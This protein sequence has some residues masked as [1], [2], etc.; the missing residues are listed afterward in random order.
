[1]PNKKLLELMYKYDYGEMCTIVCN[2]PSLLDTPI[3]VDI[4]SF[5][6]NRIYLLNENVVVTYY[7]C[8]NPLVLNQFKEEIKFFIQ[9]G[10][11]K[12]FAFLP[13]WFIKENG[14]GEIDKIV[15]IQ[16]GGVLPRFSTDIAVE[17]MW[18]GYTVT[19]V[20]MQIA[21]HMGFRKLRLI[22][23]DHDY[24]EVKKPNL[25]TTMTTVDEHHFSPDYFKGYRWN[26]PD[27]KRSEL[28]YSLAK[29][30]FAEIT[31]MSGR[32]KLDVFDVLPYNYI[33]SDDL[34]RVSAIVS[35]YKAKDY[36]YGCL[37]DLANQTEKP[38]IIVVCKKNSREEKMA[39]K[40]MKDIEDIVIVST[41]NVP[42]V[43]QAWN[44]GIKVAKGKYLTNANTDDRHHEY[45]YEVM[46]DLL[47]ERPD[48]DLVYHD[49]FITWE[50]ESYN[51]FYSKYYNVEL[52]HGRERG[53]PGI[54]S[55]HDYDR[56][57][58]S[59]GCFI[60][61]HP[62]WRANL[63]QKYGMFHPTMQ[64]A[65]DYE[66]WLRI[67][68]KNNMLHIPYPLGLYMA[69][70]DGIELNDPVTSL[71]ESQHAIKLHGDYSNNVFNLRPYMGGEYLKVELGDNYTF[72]NTQD[73][74]ETFDTLR[75][76]I[77]AK[78]E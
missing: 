5:G 64:S 10:G 22:G 19:F 12:E 38:E 50:N 36:L 52:V 43:Y 35:A 20:A 46:A 15:P 41:E 24:G 74:I 33:Q 55:W 18:E 70:E 28:A 42:T 2:G 14:L 37:H 3:P 16:T 67:S 34:Y 1:M 62:M 53:K 45:A 13:E 47:D 61:P 29:K 7:T 8:V 31:N 9:S 32:T 25:E 72:V 6:T 23:C 40:I 11:V 21:W 26:Y 27:L 58:L 71:D 56:R 65:G 77:I 68:K 73:F 69:R 78:E 54:F 60:G 44:L 39:A 48:I 75:G 63:H 76:D 51:S 59:E 30:F 4:P 17:K 49:S 57:T 66:F